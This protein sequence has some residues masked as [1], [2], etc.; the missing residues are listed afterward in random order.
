MCAVKT[1]FLTPIILLDFDIELLDQLHSQREYKAY[2][3]S[4]LS[5]KICGICADCFS[6]V[7]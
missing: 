5:P 6:G 7:K 1:L 2:I 4:V 3:P